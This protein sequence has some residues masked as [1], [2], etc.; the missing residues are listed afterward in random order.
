MSALFGLIGGVMRI[1]I[2]CHV[3][4]NGKDISNIENNVY[5]LAE[6]N[7][8][9]FTR[10]LY[11]LFEKEMEKFEADLNKDGMIS[12][13]EYFNLI[14]NLLCESK[15]TDGVVL[16]ALDAVFSQK[17]G[18]LNKKETD[19]WISNKF[20]FKKVKELN[21]RL[22]SE[23]NLELREKRFFFG[24]SVSPNRKDWKDELS[25]VINETDAVLIKLIPSAQ[26]IELM[27][28]RHEEFYKTLASNSMPL[29]CHVGPEYSFPEGIR[30]MQ[31][32][33]YKNLRK[34]L[35]CG[36]TVIA[37]HCASPVF[38]V[39]DKN[40]MQDFFQMMKEYNKGGKIKLWADTSALS[41]S[42][43]IPY[44][45]EIRKTFP[46]KWLVHGT[47]F[48]IPIDGWTHLPF[49][50]DNITP[51]EY[52]DIVRT[53]NPFDRDI[54]IKH[55]HGFSDSILENTEKVLRLNNVE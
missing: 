12:T 1:D 55:C 37:A 25:F 7:Q 31:L 19:L 32:D 10:I 28:R 53:K 49:I 38:P 36:V 39:I 24:A 35:D 46:A 29:L 15:E 52:I 44:I 43:R 33:H 18:K 5:F 9:W 6:D 45:K 26:H 47:D 48:P 2:H 34:P 23:E 22:Q 14:Y 8:H 51:S 20:L 54:K 50:T 11:N 3:A 27:D 17:T 40:F 30:N 4:G 42:S 21:Q 13:D 16:L 41:L